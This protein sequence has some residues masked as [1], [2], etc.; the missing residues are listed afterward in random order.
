MNHSRIL[1]VDDDADFLEISVEKLRSLGFGAVHCEVDPSSAAALL[2]AGEDFELALID[3]TMPGMDGIELLE[4]LRQRSPKTE[5]IM[6]TAVNDAKTA[7]RCIRSGA[8]DYLVKPVSREDLAFAVRRALERRRLLDILELG[9]GTSLPRL[10]QPEAFRP[11]VSRAPEMLRILKEAELH[12][13][14]EVPVLITGESGTGKELLARA[15]HAASSR[16]HHPFAPV[17]MASV[18]AGIFESEFFGHTRGAFTG[19]ERS[20]EGYLAH[21]RG[22][23]LF[24]DEIGQMPAELQGKLLRVLQDGEY[25]R[26]GTNDP[27]RADVRIITA[28]NADLERRVAEGTFRKDLFYRIRG[29]W[30][31]LPPLRRRRDDIPLLAGTFLRSYCGDESQCRIEEEA[32]CLLNAYDYPGNI[33]ELQSIVQ[34]AA[35]LAQGG[36]LSPR[37]LPASVRKKASAASCREPGDNPAAKP[38]AEVEKRHILAVY[39]QTG[40][41]KSQ[42]ART[43]E[44]GLNTLRRK[45]K[46]YGEG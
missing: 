30:L 45:L 40:R 7:V 3:M 28:T 23:T 5:C 42:T 21:T 12:A 14:S 43:L 41:N 39:R 9:R 13:V 19:A 16:S 44:I 1:W 18:S 34:S 2:D 11:I 22:G 31:H 27:L 24:L 35:N 15:I 17:N 46:A 20:R 38:L 37:H 10:A 26:L 8:Y 6:V 4:L 29:G 32:M 36:P 25:V 33:R